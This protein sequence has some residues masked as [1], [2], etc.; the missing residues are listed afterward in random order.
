MRRLAWLAL[1]IA[2]CAPGIRPLTIEPWREAPPPD[3]ASEAI[4][5]ATAAMGFTAMPDIH[6]YGGPGLDADCG[7]V[8]WHP[9]D[10]PAI[11]VGGEESG[12]V[13]TVA[14][15]GSWRDRLAHE[16]GH[17]I[18]E[19]LYGDGDQDHLRGMWSAGGAVEIGR[20]AMDS[21]K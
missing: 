21:E 15:A 6:W 3:G 7:G 13:L 12:G 14:A 18:S 16:L 11:C 20:V 8:A 9:L 2:G 19:E 5:L 10:A 17:A 1:A 4:Q